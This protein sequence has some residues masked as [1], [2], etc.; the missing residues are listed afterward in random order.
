MARNIKLII[1]YDGT[2]YCGWQIQDG[3]PTVQGEITRAIKRVTGKKATLYGAGR[4]DSGVHAEAQ[5]ANFRTDSRLTAQQLMYALNSKL[6]DDIVVKDA[7]EV[8]LAFNAQYD[9]R[10]KTYIYTVYNGSIRPAVQRSYC[11]FVYKNLSVGLMRKAAGYI[12]GRHNFK[13]FATKSVGRAN[14]ERTVY[15]IKITKK[16]DFIWFEVKGDGFLYNMVRNI[17]GTLLL[18]GHKKIKSEAVK[19]ILKS[20]DRR[21]AGPNIPAKGLRLVEVKY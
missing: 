14:C 21:L 18:V 8:P 16:G 2:N 20:A 3:Q 1:E 4:T 5:A 9:A 19:S 7:R 11:Y 12:K 6:P 13:S 17:V 10:G 15:S